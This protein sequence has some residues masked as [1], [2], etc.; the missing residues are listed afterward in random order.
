MKFNSLLISLSVLLILN[1]CN[2]NRSNNSYYK[3]GLDSVQ[4]INV[5]IPNSESEVKFHDFFSSSQIISLETN[6]ESLIGTISRISV[7]KRIIYILD[8]QTNTVF[9][10]NERGNFLN[11]IHD[12]GKGNGEYIGLMDFAVDEKNSQLILYCHRPYK[13]L[14]YDLKGRFIKEQRLNDLF[15]N[16]AVS[17]SGVLFLNSQKSKDYSLFINKSSSSVDNME[18]FLPLS[19][20]GILFELYGTYYPYMV[21]DKNIHIFFPY[22][23]IVYEFKD[24]KL[25]AKYSVDFGDKN[26]PE[27]MFDGSKSPGDIFKY[28]TDNDMGFAISN[29]K[30]N[31]DYVYFSYGKNVKVIYSKKTKISKSFSH[32][33]NEKEFLLFSNYFAHDGDDNNLISIYGAEEFKRHLDSFKK[34]SETWAKVPESLKKLGSMVNENDNPLLIINTLKVD[35]EI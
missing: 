3:E 2:K 9:I 28:S 14:Y 29:F 32:I 11:K 12:I 35:D 20:K 25:T 13:I 33:F 18:A 16:I 26:L 19:K 30:E 24:E 8:K 6:K 1:C 31:R 5:N 4:I 21:K 23:N 10:F 15:R 27:S 34:D 22:S 17:D 7:S